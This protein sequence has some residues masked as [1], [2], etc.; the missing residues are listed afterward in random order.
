MTAIAPFLTFDRDPYLVI[1]DGRLFWIQDAYTI[2]GQYPYS[3]RT[4]GGFNYI[5]NSVKVVVDAYHGTTTF[6]LA[7][8]ADPIALT[9]GK[10]FPG[11]LKP[12]AEMPAVAAAAHPLP[13]GHLQ[14]P[15]VR[16]TRRTT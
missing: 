13:G 4:E 16:C 15:D 5:R 11:L 2:T 14:G 9:L 8:A 10:V 1:A 6:Y 7:E 12:L 3:T